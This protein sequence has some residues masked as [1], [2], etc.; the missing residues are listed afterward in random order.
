MK[1]FKNIILNIPHSSSKMLYDGWDVS[2]PEKAYRLDALIKRWTDWRTDEIFSCSD[3]NI[4]PVI[5]EWNR[6]TVDTERLLDDPLKNIGQGILYT[7][8][9]DC[10][11]AM[12]AEL[13]ERLM[14]EYWKH[15]NLLKELL[16]PESLLIDCHSFPEDLAPDV[17]I[18]I[19]FNEDWSK[20]DD[21]MLELV[22]SHFNNHYYNVGI[23][24]PYSNSLTPDCSFYYK[25][26]MIELN[27][28]IYV[29]GVE[30]IKACINALYR[31]LQAYNI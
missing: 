21:E 20:P 28:K 19:G 25:S 16:T 26:I 8:Y 7:D 29:Q 5:A 4:H 15:I 6:F 1:H 14:G 17:D 23:N 12:S 10:H 3:S 11:R 24:N 13:S 30:N 9:E 27:K 22:A 18:C 31:K 2:T